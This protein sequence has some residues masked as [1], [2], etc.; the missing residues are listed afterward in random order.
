MLVIKSM[1]MRS[2]S[3]AADRSV[4]HAKHVMR[5]AIPEVLFA[6]S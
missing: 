6:A 3:L 4:V 1:Y 2:V 5:C